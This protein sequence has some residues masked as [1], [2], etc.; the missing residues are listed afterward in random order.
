MTYLFIVG[1]TERRVNNEK[2]DLALK[3]I[4]KGARQTGVHRFHSAG[5]LVVSSTLQRGC[6]GVRIYVR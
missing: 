1:W 3:P 2:I 4:S 5:H 6:T